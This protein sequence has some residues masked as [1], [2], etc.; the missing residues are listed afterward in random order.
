MFFI[1]KDLKIH[2]RSFS[3]Q[4]SLFQN[5]SN[6][7]RA[8]Y[9]FDLGLCFISSY[10]NSILQTPNPLLEVSYLPAGRQVEF[11]HSLPCPQP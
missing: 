8:Y 6:R 4:V 1:I 9:I 3:R 11:F 2:L 10:L 7:Q 5:F